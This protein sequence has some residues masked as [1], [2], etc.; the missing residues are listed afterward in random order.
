MKIYT[1]ANW[2]KMTSAVRQTQC[3]S[4]I[5]CTYLRTRPQTP[6]HDRVHCDDT[7][8]LLLIIKK[9]ALNRPHMM[10]RDETFSLRWILRYLRYRSITVHSVAVIK[11]AAFKSLYEGAGLK[12]FLQ[13]ASLGIMGDQLWLH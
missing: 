7:R 8:G 10:P 5:M 3:L 12:K 2:E 9:G 4:A 13:L 11:A 1:L 6:Q